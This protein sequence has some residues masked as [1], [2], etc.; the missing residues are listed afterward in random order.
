MSVLDSAALEC[1]MNGPAT[2]RMNTDFNSRYCH[3]AHEIAGRYGRAGSEKNL[4]RGKTR[5]SIEKETASDPEY[6]RNVLTLYAR[7]GGTGT[8]SFSDKGK[9]LRVYI[10][11]SNAIPQSGILRFLNISNPLCADNIRAAIA[12]YDQSSLD[13]CLKLPCE[14][15][16]I[17]P[18]RSTRDFHTESR[19][20]RL[21]GF[22]LAPVHDERLLTES[23]IDRLLF[24]FTRLLS[25]IFRTH[26]Y[27]YVTRNL[28]S[29][30][31]HCPLL[32]IEPFVSFSL[33]QILGLS[34]TS[35]PDLDR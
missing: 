32:A 30:F 18:L 4:T 20:V 7:P 29:F 6:N 13:L 25:P 17:A 9:N 28:D 2:N 35:E 24:V 21:L 27:V 1:L 22:F 12:F 3:E 26:V 23:E 14:S 8:F 11:E 33:W 5:S 10:N 15:R 16:G 34:I 19:V 31:T